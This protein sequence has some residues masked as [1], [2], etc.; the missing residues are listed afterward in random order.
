MQLRGIIKLT[1]LLP[2]FLIA[3]VCTLCIVVLLFIED[4]ATEFLAYC[5]DGE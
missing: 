1:V 5:V 2:F 4:Q 3:V